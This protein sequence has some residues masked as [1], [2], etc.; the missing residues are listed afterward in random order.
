[1][2]ERE[3][4]PLSE[5]TTLRVG[6]PADRV[7]EAENDEEI[8]EVV[9]AADGKGEP[10]LVMG[11]GSNLLVS[12]EG[13]PGTVLRVANRGLTTTID[14]RSAQIWVAA[15]EPWDGVVER[16]IAEEL[17][18]LECLS[19]IPGL[20]GATPIQ[21]VG[22][23]GQEVAQA[24]TSVRVYDREAGEVVDLAPEQCG[25]GYRTSAFKRS[26]KHVVLAVEFALERTEEAQPLRYP[27]LARRL[28]AGP[29]SRPPLAAVREAVIGLRRSKGMVLDPA[30]PDSVS[31]G[32]FFLNPILSP[33]EFDALKQRVRERLPDTSVPG[34]PEQEGGIK[35]SAGWL[36]ASAGFER[37]Y[38]RGR[39]AIS[40]KHTLALVNRGG[41]TAGE[42]A[43]LARELRDTVL[44]TFGVTLVPEPTLV[45]VKTT[46]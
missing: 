34:W 39:A 43:A 22:A 1:V 33:A 3:S 19:G 16:T 4:V 42:V 11:A 14:D 40:R 45:G 27:E 13:F 36:I 30:D 38:G 9:R 35:V 32:S 17:S 10:L 46:L 7:A 20:T 28:D 26:S 25:F 6:G 24:I 23:Y 41:A 2:R 21:N 18:G 29:G 31:A 12:D 37:G 5:L 15:G 44:A 8:I